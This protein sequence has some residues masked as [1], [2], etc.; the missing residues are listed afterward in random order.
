MFIASDS[1]FA[2]SR[3]VHMMKRMQKD[4]LKIVQNEKRSIG[5]AKK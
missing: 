1:H 3:E 5:N 2:P 4:L